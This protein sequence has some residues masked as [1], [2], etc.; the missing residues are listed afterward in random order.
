[1][2]ALVYAT[3]LSNLR[4][5]ARA[6]GYCLAVHGS[7][8]TDL[9]LVAIPWIENA[10]DPHEFIRDMCETF[11]LAVFERDTPNPQEKPHGRLSWGLQ[12]S[13]LGLKYA[14]Q[15]YIDISVMP[16]KV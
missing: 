16:M 1:M 15:T 11:D 6:Y 12:S 13:S 10:K 7:M 14:G 3:M 8:Q 5:F 4:D 9:D 2:S